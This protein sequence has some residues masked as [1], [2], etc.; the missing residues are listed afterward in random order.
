[1]AAPERT[2]PP[3]DPG[4][5]VWKLPDPSAADDDGIVG[6]GADLEP[7]TLVD[8]YRHGVFPWPHEGWPAHPWFSPNP[9]GV[10]WPGA[11]HVSRSLRQRLRR[12]GW[13]TTVDAAF[14]TVIETCAERGP[15]EGTWIWPEMQA[16]YR[17]LHQLGWARSLEVWDG[18]ELVGG[19]YGVHV[20]GVFT[21]ESM[22]HHS[23][24]ASKVALVDLVDRFSEAG[25]TAVDVQLMTEHLEA[26]GAVA[27]PRRDYLALL[28]AHVDDDV[29][30]ITDRLPVSRL[31]SR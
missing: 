24:D 19:L 17:R 20:G 4:A 12:S 9:R 21:G 23:P 31:V 8:A 7:A 16:A 27:I 29:R 28:A 1:V 10:I 13:H 6:V 14:D 18:D 30:M 15:D 2:E 25:G 22:F 26:M 11:V 3:R 5:S